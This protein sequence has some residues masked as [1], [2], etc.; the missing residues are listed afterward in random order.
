MIAKYHPSS[1]ENVINF[2]LGP[3]LTAP[4]H[5]HLLAGG[6]GGTFSDKAKG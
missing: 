3:H 5:C 2:S 1:Q 4:V 6:G